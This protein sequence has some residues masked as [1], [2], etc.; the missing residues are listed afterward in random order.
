MFSNKQTIKVCDSFAQQC[1][2][3]EGPNATH[4]TVSMYLWSSGSSAWGDVDQHWVK[5]PW[6]APCLLKSSSQW[7]GCW[8]ERKRRVSL[9]WGAIDLPSRPTNDF[10]TKSKLKINGLVTRSLA[11]L[12]PARPPLTT[13][14]WSPPYSLSSVKSKRRPT[15]ASETSTTN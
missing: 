6:R 15:S 11:M 9:Q 5:G 2:G 13:T 12:R 3:T 7:P 14:E 10:L 4:L 1:T 8:E